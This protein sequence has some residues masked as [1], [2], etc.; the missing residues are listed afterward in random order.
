MAWRT[1]PTPR[2]NGLLG[3]DVQERN[4]CIGVNGLGQLAVP[5]LSLGLLDRD[6]PQLQYPGILRQRLALYLDGIRLGGRVREPRVGIAVRRGLDGVG[7]GFGD[8]DFLFLL[9]LNG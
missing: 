3:A 6:T 7:F 5:F 4:G 8:R 2:G 1:S 9:C